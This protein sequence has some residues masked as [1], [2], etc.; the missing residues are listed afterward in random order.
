MSLELTTVSEYLSTSDFKT[1][2][3]EELGWDH[4]KATLTATAYQETFALTGIAHKR[5][6]QVF[7]CACNAYGSIPSGA[8][9]HSIQSEVKQFAHHNLIIYTDANATINIW[10]WAEWHPNERTPRVYE[11]TAKKPEASDLAE[12][13]AVISFSLEDE[14]ALTILG[15]AE[16]L[17]L[18]FGDNRNRRL[19][20]Q[21]R[22][23]GLGAYDLKEM[24]A[25]VRYWW[26]RVLNEPYLT[27]QAERR[28]AS[29]MQR[30]SKQGIDL[31]VRSHLHLVARIAWKIAAEYEC[32]TDDYFDL[33][34]MGNAELVRIAPNFDPADGARFQTYVTWRVSK[35]LIRALS[36]EEAL[37]R[38]P[39]HILDNFPNIVQ[40]RR[41]TEEALIQYHQRS[42]SPNEVE[43]CLAAQYE[44]D[45]QLV[46]RALAVLDGVLPL[47]ESDNEDDVSDYLPIDAHPPQSDF[48]LKENVTQM[49]SALKP[50]QREVIQ[51][52][53]GIDPFTEQTLEEI[54]ISFG[55]TRERIRQI[56]I[57]SL[58]MLQN[59]CTFASLR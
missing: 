56:E 34:Q 39:R 44:A 50:R 14:E 20:G 36:G 21:H 33:V 10:Q 29:A 8:A 51:R 43:E 23:A 24:D 54:A 59:N 3:I 15:V 42:V 57:R 30:G 26:E 6:A 46:S 31:L 16:Q 5:G 40:Q 7:L 58:K 11:Y 41:L 12:R 27:K 32:T 45:V 48:M 55:L 17:K 25:G 19:R 1:L 2:F 4:F 9:R 28:T 18:A 49:L 35:V 53:F 37:I 22:R 47:D 13:L 38:L 52:R